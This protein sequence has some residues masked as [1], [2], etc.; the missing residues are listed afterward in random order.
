LMALAVAT[1][2]AGAALSL[3]G[4]LRGWAWYSPVLSTVLTVAFTMAGLRALRWR[5]VFV[6]AGALA[7]L[8]LILTFT[9]FRPHSIIGFIPSGATMTQL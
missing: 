8:V 7:A 1:A 4:V 3:N 2:V 9:F 6:T 5:S